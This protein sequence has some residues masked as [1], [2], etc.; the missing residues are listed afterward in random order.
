VIA[1]LRVQALPGVCTSLYRTAAVA[2]ET[3]GTA[4]TVCYHYIP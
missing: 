3:V 4:G 1:A 2:D